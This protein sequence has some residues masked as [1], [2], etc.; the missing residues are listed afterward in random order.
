MAAGAV[1]FLPGLARRVTGPPI[2]W[3]WELTTA[4]MFLEACVSLGAFGLCNWGMRRLPVSRASAF[5]NLVPVVAV[6]IGWLLMR[7]PLSPP[8]TRR[9]WPS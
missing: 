5:I 4:L 8:R 2:T 6:A 7:E 3:G 9:P 1:F